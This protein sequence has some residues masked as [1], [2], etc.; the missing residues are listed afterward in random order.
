LTQEDH[1]SPQA[2]KMFSSNWALTEAELEQTASTYASLAQINAAVVEKVEL[3]RFQLASEWYALEMSV[4]EE[5]VRVEQVAS[6]PRSATNI[7]GLFNYRSKLVILIDMRV[8]LNLNAE[9][10]TEESRIIM[11]R[12][13]NDLTGIIVDSVSDV[14]IL[15]KANF[16]PSIS[17]I[18]GAS[19]EFI[20]GVVNHDDQ[21]L[22]WLNANRIMAEIKKQLQALS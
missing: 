15:P 16:Q 7:L 12:T 11:V 17:T 13:E 18:R 6:I 9:A 14:V 2:L 3:I 1:E 5:I 8:M 22:I 21:H 10:T 20:N 19:T 4:L